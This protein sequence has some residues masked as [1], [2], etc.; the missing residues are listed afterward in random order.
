MNTSY[1][2]N[3]A[4]LYKKYKL[5]SISRKPPDWMVVD[6]IYIP[7]CPNWNLVND[8]KSGTISQEE[9]TK[10][11]YEIYLNKLDPLKTY[12]ELEEN[13]ILLCYEKTGKFCHRR[14]VAEWLEKNLNVK[15]N[16]L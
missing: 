8:Y 15:V 16:E 10:I 2:A 11:Y 7:L 14:L 9:Y 4:I 12:N 5:V 3:P 1:F 6:K 13:A